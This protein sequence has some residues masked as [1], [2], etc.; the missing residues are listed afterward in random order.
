MAQVGNLEIEWGEVGYGGGKCL[1][2]A[3]GGIPCI[4]GMPKN[5]DEVTGAPEQQMAKYE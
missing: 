2:C 1:I 4:V 3:G 5:V